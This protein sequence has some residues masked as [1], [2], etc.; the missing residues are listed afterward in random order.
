[1]KKWGGNDDIFVI[2][3]FINHSMNEIKSGL[4]GVSFDQRTRSYFV[5]ADDRTFEI[6][7][8]NSQPKN[9]LSAIRVYSNASAE[10]TSYI[11]DM[12]LGWASPV[13]TGV[14]L[15]YKDQDKV[16]RMLREL[17][18]SNKHK[19]IDPRGMFFKDGA[20]FVVS[21]NQMLIQKRANP[22]KKLK[23]YE[24]LQLIEDLGKQL[25]INDE[26]SLLTILDQSYA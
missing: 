13:V 2:T 26:L 5:Q 21:L 3:V 11:F 17:K 9:G 25:D 10:A 16:D 12:V 1:M 18:K 23:V 6:C 24:T 4:A 7:P 19:T 8:F 15:Q 20:Y 22:G 14:E